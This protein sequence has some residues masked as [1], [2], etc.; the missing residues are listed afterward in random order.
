[1]NKTVSF[2]TH[3]SGSAAF[4]FGANGV[5]IHKL[6]LEQRPRPRHR[7]QRRVHAADHLDLVVQRTKN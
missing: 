1:M 5:K 2:R 7:L 6:A 4:A 3:G